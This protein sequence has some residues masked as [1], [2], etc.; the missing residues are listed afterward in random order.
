MNYKLIQNNLIAASRGLKRFA[1]SDKLF[2]GQFVFLSK[3]HQK[4]G[5]F[6]TSLVIFL[7]VTKICILLFNIIHISLVQVW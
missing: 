7:A 1:T 6:L 4:F 5:S 3:I 2:L